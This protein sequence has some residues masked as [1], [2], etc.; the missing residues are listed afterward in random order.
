MRESIAALGASV[1]RRPRA[2]DGRAHRPLL[3]SARRLADR[4]VRAPARCAQQDAPQPGG[5]FQARRAP[6]RLRL[7]REPAAGA[8]GG[9]CAAGADSR[10]SARRW[11][12]RGRATEQRRLHPRT[13]DQPCG[14]GRGLA[15]R[16]PDA[17]RSA[18]RRSFRRQPDL[19]AR[20]HRGCLSRRRTQRPGSRRPARV[21]VRTRAARPLHHRRRGAGAVHPGLPQEVPAGRRQDHS[22]CEQRI[23]RSERGVPGRRRLRAAR[24]GLPDQACARLSVRRRRTSRCGQRCRPGHREGGRES[25]RDAR[26]DL[27]SH[28][29]G[30]RVPGNAGKLRACRRH[31]EGDVGR[32]RAAGD[33]DHQHTARWRRREPPDRDPPSDRHCRQPLGRRP[34]HRVRS[35]CRD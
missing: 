9:G 13:I 30:R 5:C 34:S 18:E 10:R 31:A 6:R 23:H 33:G 16:L 32:A 15:Q 26:C 28:A 27:R 2:P 20:A 25:R 17:R 35:R 7:A 29:G 19:G 14:R 11:R 8:T 3:V 22:G 21:S 24:G 1:H 4:A 12:G